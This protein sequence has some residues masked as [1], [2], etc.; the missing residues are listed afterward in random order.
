MMAAELKRFWDRD[1]ETGQGVSKNNLM[2]WFITYTQI[3]GKLS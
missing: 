1:T 2:T 3:D